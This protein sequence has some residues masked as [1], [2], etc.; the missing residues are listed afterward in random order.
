M[1]SQL[2]VIT[3][4]ERLFK[5]AEIAKLEKNDAVKRIISTVAVTN[6]LKL[7]HDICI[8]LNLKAVYELLQQ[9]PFKPPSQD[10]SDKNL[11]NNRFLILGKVKRE[12]R[13]FLYP[14]DLFNQHGLLLG[15]SG[16][17]KTT[18]LYGIILQ[19]M[20][21][22]IP[23]LIVDKD[24]EDY[25]HLRRFRPELLVFKAYE[26]FIFNPLE[27]PLNVKAEHW[28]PVFVQV[29]SKTNSLLDGSESLLIRAMKKLYDEFGVFEGSDTYPTIID[30]HEKV[31]S[32]NFKGNRRDAG[33]QDSILNRLHAYID[34]N[35]EVYEYSRGIPIDWLARQSFVLEVKGLTDR[36]GRFTVS[37]LLYGLFLHRIASGQR[38]N[39]LKNLVVVDEAKWLAPYGYNQHVS[40]SPLTSVL[41]MARE[42]G[43][44]MIIG[45][46]TARLEDSVFVNSR[47]K[48]CFRLGD[49]ADI[50]KA[51]KSMSLTNDQSEYLNKMDIAECIVRIPKED[52][53]V[54]ETLDVNLK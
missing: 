13:P 23:V 8:P 24:K 18:L 40:F 36:I 28:F 9:F 7:A 53:F 12:K 43:I 2:N 22:G 54:I 30:L 48:F 3:P 50:D 5:M 41:S 16:S 49:G 37:I 39:S 21:Q 34:L 6:N 46:Q 15:A 14:A 33:F 52:P 32:Y 19:C 17:G 25:R 42:A 31:Q 38:G 4:S 11:L 29:F 35:K 44:G 45:D 27:P 26:N 1:Y 47:I 20:M 51:K 10:V